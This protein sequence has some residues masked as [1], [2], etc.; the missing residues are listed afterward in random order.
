MNY[1]MVAFFAV[2]LCN[3]IPAFA[4]PTWTLLVFFTLNYNLHGYYLVPFAILGAVLGRAILAYTFRR[5]VHLLPKGYVKNMENA[6]THIVENNKTFI[7]LL[8]LFLLAP[9]SSA[10]LFE[11]AGIMKK[12]DLK[13]LLAVFALGRVFSYSTYVGSAKLLKSSSFG[14]TFI[15]NLKSPQAISVQVLMILGVIA[16][17]NIKWKPKRIS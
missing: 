10:Q 5:Y 15:D 11:A 1:Y 7:G 12:I 6:S 13:P 4:P 3:V 9:L 17:G 2:L 16:L 14:E 8:I